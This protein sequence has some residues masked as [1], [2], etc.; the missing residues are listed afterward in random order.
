MYTGGFIGVLIQGVKRAS[1]SNEAGLGS[2]AI[3]HA[4]AKT[5][6][7]V[8]EGVVAMIGP[9]IDTHLVCTM[10]SLAILITGAHLDPSVAG[11]G[12][13]I[14]ANAFATLGS[15]DALL[16]H[17]CNDHICIFNYHFLVILW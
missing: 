8:R 6:E 9:T 13:Q 15:L 12:A 7:P 1:F 11:K 2:A 10:T 3:A 17:W 4:A 14:T 16:A 5:D